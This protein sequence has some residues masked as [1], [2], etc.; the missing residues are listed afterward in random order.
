MF[1]AFEEHE[2]LRA[3]LVVSES[4]EIERLSFAD[5]PE[6]GYDLGFVHRS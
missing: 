4:P 6:T 3:E 5:A 1:L 2:I